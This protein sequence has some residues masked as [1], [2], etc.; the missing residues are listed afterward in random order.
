MSNLRSIFMAVNDV[1]PASYPFHIGGDEVERGLFNNCTN[2]IKFSAANNVTGDISTYVT[3]WFERSLY[4]ML[5]RPPFSRRVMA[6]SDVGAGLVDETW[7]NV[8]A[9]LILEQ[10]DGSPGVWNWDVSYWFSSPP[11]ASPAHPLRVD[12]LTLTPPPCT[13]PSIALQICAS[14]AVQNASVAVAGP[15][16]I[17]HWPN[18]QE[19][20]VD[21]FNISCLNNATMS[22]IIGPET[23][24]WDDCED[25]SGTDLVLSAMK[26]IMAEAEIAWSP[27]SFIATGKVAH[28]IDGGRWNDM[29]CRLGRRGVTSHAAPYL[30]VGSTCLPEF[31]GWVA[32]WSAG[33]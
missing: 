31:E 2:A 25:N 21:L 26:T 22:Q 24:L 10:W 30:D 27:Q 19:D 5:I 20:Y 28:A 12:P 16:S 13:Q 15:F 6:W 17:L 23:M 32:P 8:S 1:F 3:S 18:P 7:T 11:M 9:N 14:L 4:E 33:G 29:R